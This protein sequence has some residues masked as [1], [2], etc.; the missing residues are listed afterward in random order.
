ML[1]HYTT[2]T[3][4]PLLPLVL[5]RIASRVPVA[6]L[7]ALVFLSS[8][9]ACAGGRDAA[10]SDSAVAAPGAGAAGA[11]GAVG[12]PSDEPPHGGTLV[13]LGG[14][15]YHLEFV[16]DTATTILTA[17][18]LDGATKEPVRLTQPRI[19]LKMLDLMEG[20]VEVYTVLA[21]KGSVK[22]GETVGNTATFMAFVPELKGRGRFR[23]VVQRV[24]VGE[25]VFT[26]IAVTFPAEARL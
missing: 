1:S 12:R 15:A 11:A 8:L 13:A 17:Y 16:L 21:A 7:L 20:N 10:P 25:K 22:T 26:D 24:E 23:A 6:S 14:G 19:D 3:T 2:P 18:V 9:V 5:Q 4:T